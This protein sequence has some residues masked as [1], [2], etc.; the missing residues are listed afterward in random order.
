MMKNQTDMIVAIVAFVLTAGFLLGMWLMKRDTVVL[1]APTEVTTTPAAMPAG[2]VTFANSLPAEG[3]GTSRGMGGGMGG[4]MGAG[5]SAMFGGMMGGP[6][7]GAGMMG[8]PGGG[9]MGGK[10]GPMG[11]GASSD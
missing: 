8:P 9:R 3:G 11:R 4:G 2:D 6:S 10:G 5:K 7:G 1:A